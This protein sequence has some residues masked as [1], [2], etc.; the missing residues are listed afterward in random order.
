MPISQL[1][2]QVLLT[3]YASALISMVK[4]KSSGSLSSH[5]ETLSI[6]YDLVQRPLGNNKGRGSMVVLRCHSRAIG[7][8][9]YNKLKA[10]VTTLGLQYRFELIL[11]HGDGRLALSTHFQKRLESWGVDKSGDSYSYL[12]L[13]HL[14]CMVI[15]TGRVRPSIRLP[16]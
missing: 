16:R 14:P 2:A 4:K 6:V 9:L 1:R 11:D 12:D 3:D 5:P 8:N 15:M 13:D 7:V 10:I